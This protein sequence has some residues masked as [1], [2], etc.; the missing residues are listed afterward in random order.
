MYKYSC[1]WTMVYKHPDPRYT[2]H[3]SIVISPEYLALFSRKPTA[4]I[5]QCKEKKRILFPPKHA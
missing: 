5:S 1:W 4:V 3:H 2:V